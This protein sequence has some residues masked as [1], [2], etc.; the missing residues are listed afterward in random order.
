MALARP[1][2]PSLID[3]VNLETRATGGGML[4]PLSANIR[5]RSPGGGIQTQQQRSLQAQRQAQRAGEKRQAHT[6]QKE[7]EAREKEEWRQIKEYIFSL[8]D[9]ELEA[10]KA[11][12]L[13]DSNYGFLRDKDPRL[14]RGLQVMI[15]NRRDNH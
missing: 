12:V 13:H 5:S 15:Y 6:E 3:R 9:D 10:E 14:D 1:D 4:A 11:A 7:Q 2:P 8:D